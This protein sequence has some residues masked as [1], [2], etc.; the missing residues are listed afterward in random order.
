MSYTSL[1]SSKIFTDDL[2][3]EEN[4]LVHNTVIKSLK[5]R[6]LSL[7]EIH[8]NASEM[9][10]LLGEQSWY[11][12]KVKPGEQIPLGDHASLLERL[13]TLAVQNPT[14]HQ[15]VLYVK[16]TN[17]LIKRCGCDAWDIDLVKGWLEEINLVWQHFAVIQIVDQNPENT[18]QKKQTL[19]H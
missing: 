6:L 4:K 18:D 17:D 7:I 9:E 16:D 19:V 15:G 10:E 5:A 14:K 13:I 8:E 3:T 12:E 1:L 11:D 2:F